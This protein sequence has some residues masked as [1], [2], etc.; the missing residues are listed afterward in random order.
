MAALPFSPRRP[1]SAPCFLLCFLLGFVAGL[2]PF[3][4]RHLRL[5]LHLPLPPPVAIVREPPSSKNAPPLLIVVTPTRV[6]P[7]QA[8]HLHRLAHTV[9]LVPPPLLW[10]VV[11]AGPAT[12]ETAELLRG[13]GVMY[14]HLSTSHGAP[15]A[16]RRRR[17]ERGAR[18]RNAALDHIERHRLHGLV[19]FAD[20][21]N[22]YTLDL[23][24][25]LRGIKSFGTW[26]VAM[27]AVGKSRTLVE[28]PVCDNSRVI[29]WHTNERNKM[30]RR[31]HVNVSGFAF[32]S[33]MLWDAKKRAHQAWNYIRLLDTVKEGFQETTFI[34]QLVEDETHMEGIPTGCSEIMNFNLR[35][36]DKHLAHPNGWQMT[37]NLDVLIPL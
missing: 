1:I 29:G 24:H 31:F 20:E 5:D 22:V 14:R 28:G 21:D 27:L 7:L 6:R 17:L 12:R 13:C 32:N 11:E 3:V 25:R 23:F 35:L 19:Y 8:Y 34:E 33:S 37:A 26:P 10:L 15:Q 2:F 4:H 18:Q 16:A 30:Q 36:E 9:R